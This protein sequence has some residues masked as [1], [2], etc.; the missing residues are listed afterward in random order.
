MSEEAPIW[1]KITTVIGC[2]FIFIS[3]IAAFMF[4]SYFV[5]SKDRRNQIQSESTRIWPYSIAGSFLLF[6]AAF[7][8]F[9]MNDNHEKIMYFIFVMTFLAIGLS[10]SAL[11]I[12]LIHKN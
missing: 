10:Y 9:N 1:V 2:S 4:I 7:L 6:I 12:A 3:C 5:G 8:Y 11:S